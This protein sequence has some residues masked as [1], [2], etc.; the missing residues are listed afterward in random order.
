MGVSDHDRNTISQPLQVQTDYRRLVENQTGDVNKKASTK[1]RSD[2]YFHLS[3]NDLL[4]KGQNRI[5]IHSSDHFIYSAE[6]GSDASAGL[7]TSTNAA[8]NPALFDPKKKYQSLEVVIHDG[9]AYVLPLN[10]DLPVL[11]SDMTK[12]RIID[13]ISGWKHDLLVVERE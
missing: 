1:N 5:S 3:P 4:K 6:N 8:L 12:Q 11:P 10:L 13:Y 7:S 9:E 2:Q